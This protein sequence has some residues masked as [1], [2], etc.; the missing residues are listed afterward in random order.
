MSLIDRLK[1]RKLVQWAL[2]YLAGAW[3]AL[4][5]VDVLGERWGISHGMARTIDVALVV[6]FIL[7]LVLAWYHGE[8][9]RQ[10]IS[11]SELLMI[12]GVLGAGALLLKTVDTDPAPDPVSSEV[13][14]YVPGANDGRPRLA[15]LVF[16]NRS[17]R[18]EDA[19]FTAGV[20]DQILTELS[21]RG[22]LTVVSRTS[23][24]EYRNRPRNIRLI[25]SELRVSH[26]VEGAVQR[27]GDSVLV[28]AQLVDATDSHIWAGDY[29]RELT[30]AG[31]LG[32]Q[33]E[34]ASNIARELGLQLVAAV[35]GPR[36]R[37]V[38][39]L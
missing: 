30:V 27:A 22:D 26:L 36:A 1:Q 9:G 2:A 16:A 34:L 11:G 20:H 5:L 15:V 24:E 21:K 19:D 28:T 7:T 6:G 33:R 23:V 35:P 13:A 38:G 8:Q 10:R 31:L 3:L 29:Q 17:R 18:P 25:A 14:A 39:S 37:A 4:Q 32:I 12:G